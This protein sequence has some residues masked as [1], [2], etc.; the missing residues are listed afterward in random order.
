LTGERCESAGIS[1]DCGARKLCGV[2]AAYKV[3]GNT[4]VSCA[5]VCCELSCTT[6]NR[7]E[8]AANTADYGTKNPGAA[9]D[10]TTGD[11]AGNRDIFL[12]KLCNTR[13]RKTGLTNAIGIGQR[14]YF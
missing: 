12:N 4:G 6:G 3:C 1:S 9:D 5:A 14:I 13:N 8:Q 10:N 2:N 11:S 7:S